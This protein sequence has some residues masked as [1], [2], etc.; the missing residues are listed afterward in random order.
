MFG[1][2]SG[3]LVVFNTKWQNLSYPVFKVTIIHFE[4]AAENLYFDACAATISCGSDLSK[5]TPDIRLLL[6]I[7]HHQEMLMTLFL[8]RSGCRLISLAIDILK[9]HS[10]SH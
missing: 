5:I 9:M 2:L 3:D 10:E 4:N 8:L 1:D 6:M 7:L